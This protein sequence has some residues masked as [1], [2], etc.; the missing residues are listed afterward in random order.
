LRLYRTSPDLATTLPTLRQLTR[1]IAELEA[2]A[3]DALQRI[4]QALGADYQ[5]EL[6]DS[7]CEIG[8]GAQPTETLPSKAIAIRHSN[9][10]P[11]EIAARF[12]KS[13]PPILGRVHDNR[14]WLDLRCIHAPTDV[15]PRT[16]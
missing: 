14:F 5:L 11:L 12:R 3:G 7:Q 6:V 16:S 2:L 15:V 4:A 13:D 9:I 8:S 10:G 1:P